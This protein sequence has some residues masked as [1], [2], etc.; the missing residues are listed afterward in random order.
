MHLSKNE[1]KA[2]L[3]HYNVKYARGMP[4]KLLRKTAENELAK[5]LCR[6]IK[7]VKVLNPDEERAIAICKNSVVLKKNLGIYKFTCRKGRRLLPLKANPKGA[8]LYKKGT[9]IT[10]RQRRL[11]KA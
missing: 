6:C 5:T 11:R 4:L 10:L 7:K 9:N 1:Y 3:D 2:I 8:A